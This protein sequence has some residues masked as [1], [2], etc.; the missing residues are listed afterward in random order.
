MVDGRNAR[1]EFTSGYSGF[2]YLGHELAVAV[3]APNVYEGLY[4]PALVAH[5]LAHA[6]GATDRYDDWPPNIMSTHLVC[7]YA[8]GVVHP[9]TERELG[10]EVWRMYLPEV[11][12]EGT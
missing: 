6:L 8:N 9:E 5:E 12:K 7:A 10:W 3:Y 2:A 4:F 11:R 1:G